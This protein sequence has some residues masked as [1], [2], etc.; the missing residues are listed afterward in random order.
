MYFQFGFRFLPT[1]T[2]I[3]GT[4]NKFTWGFILKYIKRILVNTR[5][6]KL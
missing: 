6:M 1:I 2:V 4:T 5:D 3:F